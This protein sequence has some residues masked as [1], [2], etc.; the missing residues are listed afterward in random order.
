MALRR[1]QLSRGTLSATSA[2]LRSP[3]RRKFFACLFELGTQGGDLFGLLT[4]D[5]LPVIAAFAEIADGDAKFL[6]R[7]LLVS[8]TLLPGVS[9]AAKQPHQARWRTLEFW[10]EHNAVFP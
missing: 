4:S 1:R 5:I 3:C 7:L 9:A 6:H 10:S 8:R 2:F